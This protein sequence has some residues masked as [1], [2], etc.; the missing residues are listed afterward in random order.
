MKQLVR[1]NQLKPKQAS[2]SEKRPEEASR[3]KKKTP[4][5]AN[6]NSRSQ[7]KL[8]GSRS[9]KLPVNHR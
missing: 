7:D 5:E 9:Q 3:S 1:K 2:R 8:E 6:K 4:E